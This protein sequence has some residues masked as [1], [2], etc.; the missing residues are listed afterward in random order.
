MSLPATP[1]AIPQ[2]FADAWNARDP[3]ALAALFDEDAT[4][5]NVVGLWW[6]D[7]ASIREA[8]AYG[9]RV[10]FSD[11]SLRVGRR[12]VKDLAPGVALVQARMRLDG[13]S[14]VGGVRQ[15]GVR[16]TVF[17][18]VA[19]ETAAGWRCASAH[20]TDV[21]AGAETHVRDAEG[22]LL[23]ADYRSGRVSS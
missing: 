5:V 3:G 7:R 23:D 11:S 18:F 2:A 1:S 14:A 21:V 10:L 13:Q 19:R 9:L 15:P 22:R 20:N 8:H 6:H 4:F 17:S 16:H 12:V